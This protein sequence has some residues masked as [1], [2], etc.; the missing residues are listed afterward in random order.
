MP[1]KKFLV[2]AVRGKASYELPTSLC[3]EIGR[4]TVRW[5]FFERYLKAISW[6]F[7]GVDAALGRISIR[8]PKPKQLLE[9]VRDIAIIQKIEIDSASL[10]NMLEHV[11]TI[12]SERDLITHGIWMHIDGE[13]NIQRVAGNWPKQQVAKEAPTGSR[14]VLP[15]GVVMSVTKLQSLASKIEKLIDHAKRLR[16]TAKLNSG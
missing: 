4:I 5:A 8:D 9:M 1:S 15:E 6:E 16:V 14:R 3:R 2:S 12:S 13:W 7:L 10:K 11:E